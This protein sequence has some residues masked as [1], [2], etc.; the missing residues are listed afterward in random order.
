MHY[1][2]EIQLIVGEVVA[3]VIA[4]GHGS[5]ARQIVRQHVKRYL[6]RYYRE[7]GDLP[8]G[9][10][11]LGMTRPLHLEVGMVNFD[12]IR[13]RVRAD[14]ETDDAT[15]AEV[16]VA[17]N[18]KSLRSSVVS[19]SRKPSTVASVSRPRTDSKSPLSAW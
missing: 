16:G 18:Q 11:Y 12:A 10:R 3:G 15:A 14:S 8:T 19:G 17:D 4:E 6:D 7:H 13:Q 5:F 2:F 9:R 1:R